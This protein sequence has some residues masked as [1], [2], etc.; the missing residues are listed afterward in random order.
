MTYIAY[1]I[2]SDNTARM[3]PFHGGT[4]DECYKAAVNEL[5]QENIYAW[6]MADIGWQANRTKTRK[7]KL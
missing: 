4:E 6:T 5:G 2:T 3:K 1:Y 7:E